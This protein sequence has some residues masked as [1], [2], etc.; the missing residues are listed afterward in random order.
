MMKKQ[1]LRN[2]LCYLLVLTLIISGNVYGMGKVVVCEAADTIITSLDYFDASNGP[3]IV[4]DATEVAS[5]GFVM[6]KFNGMESTQLALNDVL[7]D[8]VLEVQVGAQWS[9]ID[10]VDYFV[11]NGTWGWEHQI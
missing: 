4:R 3:T 5:F 1:I 11:F 10:D 8:L 7:K 6:P 9:H 2:S